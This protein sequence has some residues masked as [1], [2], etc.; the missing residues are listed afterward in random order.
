M[1]DEE[2]EEDDPNQDEENRR[3]ARAEREKWLQ[4]KQSNLSEKRPS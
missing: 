2:K 1:S 3:Q 4:G